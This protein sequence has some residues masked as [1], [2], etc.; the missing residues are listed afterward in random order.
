MS[1]MKKC[2]ECNVENPKAAN[3]CRKCRYEFPE[4][5]KDGLS[6][7]PE[8]KYLR[9]RESQYV[10][11]SAIHIE[12]D[13]DN[14][15][16]VELAGEDVTLYK[17]V[18]LVV[19]K[20]VELE[21]V[22]SNDYD[23]AKQSI[24]VVPYSSPV[25]R[26]FSSSHS[27]IKAGKTTK[28]SWSVDYAKK[29]LLKSPSEEIDATIMS[30]LEISPA[31]DTTYTLVSYA[32]DESISVSKDITVR[33]LHDVAIND[34][35]SDIPQTLESQPV[36][37]RWDIEN[38]DKI[39]LYPNDIDITHQN[40]LKIFPNRAM[41]YRIVASNAISIKEALLSI[42]VRP[43]PRLDIKVSDSL[44]RLEIPNCEID[45]TP[46]TTSIKE[47]DLDR[48][49]LSPIEQSVTKT[50]WGKGLFKRIKKILHK[51]IKL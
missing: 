37:L 49:M 10:V 1:E 21:L 46:L 2:P 26:R 13:V 33:V 32:V 19:E 43:L 47:T 16:K 25:I 51:R 35:S 30:E 23:Q 38:A 12:W 4:A 11:G 24:R 34:F 48:W 50:I 18:E 17:D 27:N 6:L 36:E 29:V 3:F 28:L 31:N 5:T 15:T 44:S 22:A 20:A 41:T 9:I 7:S 40:S 8:I 45:L 39:M 14:Y 42:G